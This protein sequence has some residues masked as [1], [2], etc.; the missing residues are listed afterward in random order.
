MTNIYRVRSLWQVKIK[1]FIL[2]NTT[3]SLKWQVTVKKANKIFTTCKEN[4]AIESSK[5]VT[6]F[7]SEKYELLL[8]KDYHLL[9]LQKKTK[10]LL[11]GTS[12]AGALPDSAVAAVSAVF[13]KNL[14][15]L[16][17]AVYLFCS[18]WGLLCVSGGV[19]YEVALSIQN[20]L[21]LFVRF[22]NS[23]WIF[24]QVTLDC[25]LSMETELWWL[26]RCWTAKVT[27]SPLA[28]THRCLEKK[29]PTWLWSTSAL[30]EPL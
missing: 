21:V 6:F 3:S 25:D 1:F 17:E 13:G 7:V 11:A 2:S 22:C 14:D 26:C 19:D 4:I 18:C 10:Q 5:Q 27:G 20:A 12:H 30:F 23:M 8:L 29:Y 16:L 24:K 9:V 28:Q 15:Q